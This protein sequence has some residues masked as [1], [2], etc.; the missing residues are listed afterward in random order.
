MYP[1]RYIYSFVAPVISHAYLMTAPFFIVFFGQTN[2]EV[3]AHAE[4][5]S[6]LMSL[7]MHKGHI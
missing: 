7:S 1:N 5:S 6:Y 3:I 4:S 2:T